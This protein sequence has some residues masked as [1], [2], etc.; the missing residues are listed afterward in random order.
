MKVLAVLALVSAAAPF[1]RAAG[2]VRARGYLRVL[3]GC[4]LTVAMHCVCS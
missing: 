4:A 2:Q 3:L 1:L